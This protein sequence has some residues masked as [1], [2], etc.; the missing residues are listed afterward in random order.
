MDACTHCRNTYFLQKIHL[1]KIL[2]FLLLFLVLISLFI[3]LLCSG[4]GASL[5]GNYSRRALPYRVLH[6]H[7]HFSLLL[8]A[9]EKMRFFNLSKRG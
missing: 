5:L 3:S 4:E 6:K 8:Q 7:V 2:Q 1:R 9:V